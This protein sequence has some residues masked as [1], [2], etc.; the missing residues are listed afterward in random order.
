MEGVAKIE[1]GERK[2]LWIW[3]RGLSDWIRLAI[4]R[5]LP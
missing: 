3:T 4:W 2:L 5:W 1:V